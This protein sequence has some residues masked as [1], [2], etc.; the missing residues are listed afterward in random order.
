MDGL[1][2]I[3]ELLAANL[4]RGIKYSGLFNLE[5]QLTH[6][7]CVNAFAYVKR[8]WPSMT[9]LE[10]ATQLRWFLEDFADNFSARTVKVSDNTWE[11][12]NMTVLA[13]KIL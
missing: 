4:K 9:R 11:G 1:H 6:I 3:L 10:S 8:A 13:A 12:G 2:N 5:E 7:H